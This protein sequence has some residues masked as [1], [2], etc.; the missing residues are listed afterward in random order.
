VS[1]AGE[2]E[3]EVT[4]IIAGNCLLL[5]NGEYITDSTRE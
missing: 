3:K 1:R 4:S 2:E 5:Y